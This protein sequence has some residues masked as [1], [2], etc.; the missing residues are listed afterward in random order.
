VRFVDLVHLQ[1]RQRD[2]ACDVY[3]A[4][5]KPR[6]SPVRLQLNQKII[7]DMDQFIQGNKVSVSSN[8][9]LHSL[10]FLFSR[11][12]V[13]AITDIY[14][15]YSISIKLNCGLLTWRSDCFHGL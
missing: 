1:S 4:Y 14:K 5:V 8:Y 9:V 10:C 6:S 13:S 7:A 11:H 3:R 2:A 15:A 12:A